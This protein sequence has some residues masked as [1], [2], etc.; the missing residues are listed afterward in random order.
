MVHHRPR[1]GHRSFSLGPVFL[2]MGITQITAAGLFLLRHRWGY[3]FVLAMAVAML[4][5]LIFGT[6]SSLAQI[7]LVWWDRRA[8]RCPHVKAV[9]PGRT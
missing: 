1:S 9:R 2:L 4:W 8:V 6:I 5:Y 7:A 3:A